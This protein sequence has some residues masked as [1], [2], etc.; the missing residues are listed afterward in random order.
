MNYG[1]IVRII[2]RYVVGGL[3][4][5]SHA[6]GERLAADPDLVAIGAFVLGALV[7]VAYIWAKKTGRN[8]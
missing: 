7:E 4:I 1:P 5:G 3:F 2:L 8:T 6:V